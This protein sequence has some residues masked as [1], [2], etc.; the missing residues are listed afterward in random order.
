LPKEL[1]QSVYCHLNRGHA[2]GFS[3]GSKGYIGTGWD[4]AS[5]N[6]KDFWEYDPSNDSWTKKADFG[7]T[8]RIWAVGFSIG[9]KG[10]VGTGTGETFYLRDF[11]E[12]DPDNNSWT[13]K[14][15][16]GG[17]A[18]VSAVGLSIGS[19]GYI[20][21]ACSEPK[22]Y[23]NEFW[24]YDPGNNS[25][26]QKDNYA[27]CACGWTASFSIGTR[28]YIGIG[29]DG[30]GYC[31]DFWKYGPGNN[32]WSQIENYGGTAIT[33]AK[34]FSIGTKGYVGMGYHNMFKRDFWEY[35]PSAEGTS[36]AMENF[37]P[38]IYPNPALNIIT[39]EMDDYQRAVVEIINTTGLLQF[40][41]ELNSSKTAVDIGNFPKGMYMVKIKNDQRIIMRKIIKN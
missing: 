26:T 40:S 16:Y 21:L 11:W 22:P 32:T 35:D 2:V 7:G 5:N 30:G 36:D 19:K 34:G 37:G 29:G 41:Y 8:A 13:R 17:P 27:G 23:S 1:L 10:Y 31:N 12:Y 3:V 33:W 39:I 24:E 25:W 6:L 28:G 18:T 14:S 20:G 9:S 15:D 38:V 4:S